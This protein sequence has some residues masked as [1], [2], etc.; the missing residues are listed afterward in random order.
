M[1][2]VLVKV[3]LLLQLDLDW[4]VENLIEIRNIWKFG[5]TKGKLKLSRDELKT[6]FC[7][8]ISDIWNIQVK[9]FYLFLNSAEIGELNIFTPGIKT[10]DLNRKT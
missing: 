6:C 5:T 10:L 1:A 3:K 7:I 8:S 2:L 9:V 4:E